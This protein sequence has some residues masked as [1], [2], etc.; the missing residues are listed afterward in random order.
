MSYTTT[1]PEG[2]DFVAVPEPLINP[3]LR[4]GIL[5]TCKAGDLVLW[6]SR[7]MHCNTPAI[8]PPSAANGYS[9]SELLRAV[10]YVC[11]TPRRFAS[12][13]TLSQRRRAA[14]VGLGTTHWPHE[15]YPVADPACLNGVD[16]AALD[17][18]A[19][20]GRISRERRDLIG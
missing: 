10:V 18:A 12:A 9:E 8:E 15:F 19:R 2:M 20:C 11:M 16:E 4:N 5:V 1:S 14:L 17:E 13:S 3:V 6:D 7:T